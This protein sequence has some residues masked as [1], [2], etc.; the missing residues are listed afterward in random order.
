MGEREGC[1]LGAGGERGEG[2]GGGG[3][4]AE[5]QGGEA[6]VRCV[7]RCAFRVCHPPRRRRRPPLYS[8]AT[9]LY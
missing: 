6:R 1:G 3:A 8:C 5:V 7:W 9:A 4:G 2:E